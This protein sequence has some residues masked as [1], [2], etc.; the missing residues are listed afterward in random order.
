MPPT[1]MYEHADPMD[2]IVEPTDDMYKQAW[3][4]Y[5][6]AWEGFSKAP[7]ASR[8]GGGQLHTFRSF[9]WPMLTPPTELKD[10]NKDAIIKFIHRA[11]HAELMNS[12]VFDVSGS[13]GGR[14]GGASST[15]TPKQTKV[16]L[17]EARLRWH[18]D[19]SPRWMA[20]VVDS[21][22]ELV[23]KGADI[24]IRVLN[25]LSS[26]ENIEHRAAEK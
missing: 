24:V 4:A 14:G 22:K 13:G 15:N 12:R 1:P 19:R 6:S 20:H 3:A 23:R 2:S 9:P 10:L 25:A 26:E 17:H 8:R 16:A 5:V 18:P 21:E 11:F 7:S